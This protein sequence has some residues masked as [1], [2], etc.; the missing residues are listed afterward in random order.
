M[1][2]EVIRIFANHLG[3]ET[4]NKFLE[5]FQ[6][7]IPLLASIVGDFIY[8]KTAQTVLYRWHHWFSKDSFER[9]GAIIDESTY[10]INPDEFVTYRPANSTVFDALENKALEIYRKYL[11]GEVQLEEAIPIDQLT[12]HSIQVCPTNAF[13]RFVFLDA[14]GHQ[15]EF[16][17]DNAEYY[18]IIG[19]NASLVSQIVDLAKARSISVDN[20]FNL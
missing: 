3:I 5:K 16:K 6:D 19:A 9:G 18:Q 20:F 11:L 4:E 15:I 1:P 17:R 2:N 8:E 7:T 14:N 10:L 13:L 12:V